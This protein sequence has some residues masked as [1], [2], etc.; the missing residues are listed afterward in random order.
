MLSSLMSSMQKKAFSWALKWIVLSYLH[1]YYWLWVVFFEILHDSFKKIVEK[2][3]IL[4]KRFSKPLDVNVKYKDVL[5]V[6]F[7]G[8][9]FDSS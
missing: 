1:T 5:F 3:I 9:Y 6:H 2:L 7:Q 4:I 8:H